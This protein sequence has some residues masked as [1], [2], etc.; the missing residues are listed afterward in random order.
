MASPPRTAEAIEPMRIVLRNVP[1]PAYKALRDEPA[2]NHLR[3]TY[4]NGTLD[5]MSPEFVH[6]KGTTRLSLLVRAVARTFAITYLEASTT[7]FR[8]RRQ[9]PLKGY[10]LEAD[11]SFYFGA[12]AEQIAP[13]RHLSLRVDPPPD[14]AIEV[15]STADSR[16]KL[17]VYAR[18]GF[19]EVWRYDVE[20]AT[21]WFGRLQTDGNNEPIERS[22]ALPMLHVALVRDIVT[23]GENLTDSRFEE[24]VEAGIRDEL[25]PPRP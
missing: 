18:L 1:W 19:P 9:K 21:L 13:K 12:H 17:G 14:L 10:G 25:N 8:R 3:M 7:T 6:S 24:L 23:R 20:A 2:N 22:E 16:W 5:I 15:D 4:L 11:T